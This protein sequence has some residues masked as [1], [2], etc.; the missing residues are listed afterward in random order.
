LEKYTTISISIETKRL[1]EKR[2]KNMDWDRFLRSLIER[3][4]ELE[5]IMAAKELEGRFTEDDEKA[6]IESMLQHK[7]NIKFR[8]V[9][10]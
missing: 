1:L 10:L 8:E 7:R 4:E 6:A 9:N 2:K 3:L 5:K